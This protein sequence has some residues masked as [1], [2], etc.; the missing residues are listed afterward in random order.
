FF[1]KLFLSNFGEVDLL[2]NIFQ[3]PDEYVQLLQDLKSGQHR[4]NSEVRLKHASGSILIGKMN[5]R[6]D[7]DTL[8]QEIITWVVL[9]I[10]E[11]YG[12]Q[13]KFKEKEDEVN[14]LK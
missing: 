4:Y 14:K 11:Q 1:N 7:Y 8:G 6:C 5:V 9:D 12:F 2:I 13:E 10:T 3:F